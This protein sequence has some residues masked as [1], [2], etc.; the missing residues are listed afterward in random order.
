M[1]SVRNSLRLQEQTFHCMDD[2][3]LK[4]VCGGNTRNTQNKQT[5]KTHNLSLNLFLDCAVDWSIGHIKKPNPASKIQHPE[6]SIQSMLKPPASKA[7]SS[8]VLRTTANADKVIPLVVMEA[9]S[10]NL[11][12][13]R[14]A[15]N[16]EAYTFAEY[17]D[18]YGFQHALTLWQTHSAEQ[19][20][21]TT[22]GPP[23]S[24]AEQPEDMNSAEQ[25]V[26]TIIGPLSLVPHRP[27]T[28]SLVQNSLETRAVLT[29]TE[30][31]LKCQGAYYGAPPL[32]HL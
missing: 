9:S 15:Q 5:H 19:P 12:E 31:P 26:D 7:C 11:N 4:D 28:R 18:F 8:L 24:R 17:V 14:V 3:K 25:P 32:G 27:T 23:E 20:V 29:T 16:G 22:R 13:R 21:D 2:Q 30:P 1:G 6:S 10:I